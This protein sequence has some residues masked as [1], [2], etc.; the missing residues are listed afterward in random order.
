MSQSRLLADESAPY[1]ALYLLPL[2]D[3][4]YPPK[5]I[6]L[7][8][9]GTRV[10]V[11]RQLN[12]R[13]A[14]SAANGVFESRVLSRQHAEAWV[15]E[16]RMFIR[17]VKSSNGT[18]INSERLSAEGA[19]SAACE[20][21]SDDI[22]EFGIDI[23]GET[24]AVVH[25]KV[26]ARVTCAFGAADAR[27]AVRAEERV[28]PPA[29]SSSPPGSSPNGSGT[30]T[31]SASNHPNAPSP[32]HPNAQGNANGGGGG[33]GGN[34][35]TGA[36]N[37]NPRPQHATGL[38]GMGGMGAERIRPRSAN[39]DSILARLRDGP[40]LSVYG[41]A[42]A[43]AGASGAAGTTNTNTNPNATPAPQTNAELAARV[44]GFVHGGPASQ[45]SQAHTLCAEVE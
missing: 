18:F 36:G 15:E 29:S 12:Q 33:V 38:A 45:A 37:A 40:S 42:D 11:G 16:E 34:A 26:A 13:A 25:R 20:L 9:P 10:R 24:G 2:D 22:L 17:D 30:S 1:P 31:P 35:N 14:P 41:N 8:P 3:S 27:R 32:P 4:F 5:R 7:Y 6:P 44:N 19:D 39:F 28:Y 43:G 23:V 21:R